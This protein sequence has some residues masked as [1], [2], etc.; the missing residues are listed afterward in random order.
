MNIHKDLLNSI[1]ENNF[2]KFK[3]ILYNDKLKLNCINE[4]NILNQIL[5]NNST[6]F[7]DEFIKFKNLSIV[8]FDVETIMEKL[9]NLN[10]I[11]FVKI[12]YKLKNIDFYLTLIKIIN[13]SIDLDKYEV[14][15]FILENNLIDYDL[16]NY[17]TLIYLFKI[18]N[19][20][21]FELLFNK[22]EN[23]IYEL[24]EKKVFVYNLCQL[25]GTTDIIFKFIVDKLLDKYDNFIDLCK[26]ENIH[27]YN[28][29]IFKFDYIYNKKN[30]ETKD[31]F[32]DF[33]IYYSYSNNN[34]ELFKY[35]L[36][37]FDIDEDRLLN[38]LKNR[39]LLVK[40]ISI[41]NII[42]VNTLET[43]YIMYEKCKNKI[44]T[45]KNDLILRCIQTN[46]I[47]ILDKI[48]HDDKILK[49]IK[50]EGYLI[51]EYN[52]KIINPA[53][54]NIMLNKF[55][56]VKNKNF[57]VKY[58]ENIIDNNDKILISNLLD[59]VGDNIELNKFIS[60]KVYSYI[61]NYII[62]NRFIEGDIYDWYFIEWIN[63]KFSNINLL[64]NNKNIILDNL[65]SYEPNIHFVYWYINQNI[66]LFDKSSL[67]EL[68]IR[69]HSNYDGI[70]KLM[71]N[72]ID[73]DNILI[74][75]IKDLL[76]KDF[77]DNKRINLLKSI[78]NV[79]NSVEDITKIETIDEDMKI[80][81]EKCVF[82][83]KKFFYGFLKDLIFSSNDELIIYI[84]E[85]I[86]NL[87]IN[88]FKILINGI[89][90]YKKYYL[91]EKMR[92]IDL[93]D[94]DYIKFYSKLLI[95]SI[96]FC[97]FIIFDL[98]Y[99]R[100]EKNSETN[101]TE[102]YNEI[103]KVLG[104]DIED[105]DK[106]YTFSVK[107]YNYM[108][109]ENKKFINE[110]ILFRFGREKIVI[111]H[112][113]DE[114]LNLDSF[115]SDYK[116]RFFKIFLFSINRYYVK[117]LILKLK[118]TKDDYDMFNEKMNQESQENDVYSK[119]VKYNLLYQSDLDFIL[120]L[121]DCGLELKFNNEIL[122][123]LFNCSYFNKRVNE[124]LNNL[125]IL[126][127]IIELSKKNMFDINLE[128]LNIF[129]ENYHKIKYKIKVNEV[130]FLINNYDIE[131]N[132]NTI[133]YSGSSKMKNIFDYL[134]TL[135]D[136]NLKENDE[137][138][139]L[140]VCLNNDV[141]FAKYLLEIEPTFDISRNNDNI[142]SQC[143]NEGVLESI[144]W[145]FSIIPNM[146]E[147]TKYEYSI[148]GACYYGHLETAKWLFKNIDNLDIK[149]DNDYCMVS[150]IEN[151]HFDLVDWILEIEPERYNVIYNEEFNEILS[152]EINKKLIIEQNKIVSNIIEC[153]I[154]YE[155]TS[156]IVTC[157][158][159]QFCY[160]CFSEYYKKNTNINCPYCRKENIMLFNISKE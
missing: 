9:I 18:K 33:N 142:F 8:Y 48:N 91:L 67:E 121:S 66:E 96:K 57:L 106:F 47:L 5:D 75:K 50:I 147:P 136:F 94:K 22:S 70:N 88:S 31:E 46:N 15:I 69:L 81:F 110:L 130:K 77:N 120:Y 21:C 30:N 113:I 132:F 92:T 123:H 126:E 49:S 159:H 11:D 131:I 124:K 90:L 148:C 72:N 80:I 129:L 78:F 17:E 139:L 71:I 24:F 76:K 52:Y 83:D 89:I 150:C 55:N 158:E 115:E 84:F 16:I 97:D 39:N 137:D 86:K 108:N 103:N 82:K 32:L 128:T 12:L 145:L 112:F 105:N 98:A 62:F 23:I 34:H 61:S 125:I 140:Q 37:K 100:L 53:I 25:Y 151:E 156:N 155:N 27:K 43:S 93:N 134:I 10:N 127:L 29:S 51:S 64:E 157:C 102:I 101:K 58:I 135:G 114:V 28:C 99:Q 7:L 79:K 63:I 42:Q 3:E 118:F 65:T 111:E 41:N 138:L 141:E 107:I 38:I 133:Y 26:F 87:K 149:V 143:C 104:V 146:Y 14:L 1:C 117:D 116:F 95:A 152:F 4:N 154:C 40:R 44:L 119:S 74:D 160:K 60:K 2:E 56:L 68:L 109:D 85:K 20:Y 19:K 6:Q 35:I 122:V 36:D 153:P 144:I 73:K 59:S 54:I 13:I 45:N